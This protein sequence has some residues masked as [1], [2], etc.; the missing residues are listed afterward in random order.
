VVMALAG[1]CSAPDRR[2]QG[3]GKAVVQASL[4]LVDG[5]VYQVSLFQTSRKVFPFYEKLGARL[6]TNRIVNSLAPDPAANPFWDE[7]AMS[8]PASVP[9]PEG[10]IDLLGPGY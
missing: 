4:G 6:V 10:P 9:W 8:Y 3:L 2:G 5:G 7:V 1:V